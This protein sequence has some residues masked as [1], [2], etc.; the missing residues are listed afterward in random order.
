MHLHE[1]VSLGKSQSC[2]WMLLF[3]VDVTGTIFF[4]FTKPSEEGNLFL[5][6][7]VEVQRPKQATPRAAPG[8]ACLLICLWPWLLPRESLTCYRKGRG[9][10]V[11]ATSQHP[12]S[13]PGHD[14]QQSE[15]TSARRTE[16]SWMW[17]S[18]SQ[19][20]SALSLLPKYLERS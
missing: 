16:T 15:L 13:H 1:Q 8:Q 6:G 18:P 17:W 12:V 20:R 4:M 14:R 10:S 19:T 7:E 2:F 9:Q 3:P 11:L 5:K